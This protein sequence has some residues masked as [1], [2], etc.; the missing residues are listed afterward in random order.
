MEYRK[1]GR[2]DLSVSVM[3]H[4]LWGMGD[5]SG[6]NDAE[7]LNTLVASSKA[8]CTFFDSARAYG[9]GKS[10]KLLGELI[11]RVGREK[12]IIGAKVAPKNWKWP[13]TSEDDIRDV[14]PSEYIVNA[15]E[16][17]CRDIGTP[18]IEL[19]Q[20]HV[21]DD[22]W[23]RSSEWRRA[24]DILKSRKVIQAFGISVNRWEP[25]N[26]VAALETGLVDAVQVIYNIFDQSPEDEL[27]PYCQ[28][29]NIAV[30]ARVP[31]DEG[32]LTGTLNADTRFPS[33]DWR[34]KYFGQENLA[35]T[36]ERVAALR[37][38][39]PEFPLPELALRFAI[40]HP[41][42]TTAI[43]GM[44]NK[45]HLAENLTS[46][47]KGPLSDDVVKRLKSHRWDRKVTAWA[48]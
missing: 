20:L 38:A 16:E 2:S 43:V 27:F 45:A 36:L 7:S 28:K 31:F 5:W 47:G 19:L 33:N 29:R 46:I 35:P 24:I 1:F 44:R 30:I 25:T 4:G 41:A 12:V 9:R 6:S 39:F 22:H 8:G 34:S 42:V 21:W 17:I 11:N 15:T 3:G 23:A 40:T 32:S 13:G 26:V 14:F 48:N 10:D 37:T 18:T